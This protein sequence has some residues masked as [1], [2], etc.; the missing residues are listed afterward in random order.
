[1]NKKGRYLN[2]L[3]DMFVVYNETCQMVNKR[4][5]KNMD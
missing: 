5:M 4:A 2:T 3:N 1:M